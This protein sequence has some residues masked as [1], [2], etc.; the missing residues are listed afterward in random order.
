MKTV[1]KTVL[2]FSCV[3][4][5]LVLASASAYAM[6]NE[7]MANQQA[8]LQIAFQNLQTPECLNHIH[9]ALKTVGHTPWLNDSFAENLDNYEKA[10]TGA[11]TNL[12]KPQPESAQ[13]YY[14]YFNRVLAIHAQDTYS[15]GKYVVDCVRP[16]FKLSASQPHEIQLKTVNASLQLVRELKSELQPWW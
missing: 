9:F 11:R 16:H 1:M 6:T 12:L 4:G 7:E 13:A 5:S 15:G 8:A 2:N 3:L 10:L 14:D